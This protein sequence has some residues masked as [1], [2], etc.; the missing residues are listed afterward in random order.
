ML[1]KLALRLIDTDLLW[2]RDQNQFWTAWCS[3]VHTREFLHWQFK[4]FEPEPVLVSELGSLS[5]SQHYPFL[6]LRQ[7]DKSNRCIEETIRNRVS[8]T[9]TKTLLGAE[10]RQTCIIMIIIVVAVVTIIINC[11]MQFCPIEIALKMKK[12]LTVRFS[13]SCGRPAKSSYSCE[14]AWVQGTTEWSRYEDRL[15][16]WDL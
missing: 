10:E 4:H 1:K 5:E 7:A 16:W 13:W 3:C 9:L 11:S 8:A 6:L 15:S 2:Y 14:E 12:V